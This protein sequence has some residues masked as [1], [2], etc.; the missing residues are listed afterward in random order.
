MSH[1]V[2]VTVTEDSANLA[3][4]GIITAGLVVVA[5]FAFA[6]YVHGGAAASQG[7]DAA[8]SGAGSQA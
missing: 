8:A 6:F 4:L 5:G 1:S 3:T 7:A 2:D